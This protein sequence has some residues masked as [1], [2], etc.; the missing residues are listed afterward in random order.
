M[1]LTRHR[2]VLQPEVQ[3]Q[4]VKPPKKELFVFPSFLVV[5]LAGGTLHLLP[6]WINEGLLLLLLM[7]PLD[8]SSIGVETSIGVAEQWV[9]KPSLAG[10]LS[11]RLSPRW[12]KQISS[13]DLTTLNFLDYKG[14]GDELAALCNMEW[15]SVAITW[16]CRKDGK[17]SFYLKDRS[18]QIGQATCA[19]LC[20]K[21]MW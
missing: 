10:K 14:M 5:V 12:R 19:E 9:K 1:V 16:S 4:L 7:F 13:G 8:M 15:G 21:G 17:C 3:Q 18:W 20:T 2:S 6:W 11:A